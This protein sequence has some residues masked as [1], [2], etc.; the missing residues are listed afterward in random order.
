MPLEQRT[1]TTSFPG[2][3]RLGK[4]Q[5]NL[6]MTLI[7]IWTEYL[8]IIL[9]KVEEGLESEMD[10]LSLFH[11]QLLYIWE[12]SSLK[13]WCRK[14]FCLSPVTACKGKNM[15]SLIQWMFI[16]PFLQWSQR[17]TDAFF[18]SI[19][20]SLASLWGMLFWD[21]V[22]FDFCDMMQIWSFSFGFAGRNNLWRS[23]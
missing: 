2:M 21:P 23:H 15:F 17:E 5:R 12:P 1:I 18:Q 3:N 7:D 14:A 6:P 4:E 8:A 13:L 9:V 20:L 19:H 11:F 10:F 22:S 16:T